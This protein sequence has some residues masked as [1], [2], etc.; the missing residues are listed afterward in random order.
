MTPKGKARLLELIIE[1][2]VNGTIQTIQEAID[3]A[4]RLAEI[5]SKEF[6]WRRT[7]KCG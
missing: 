5:I 3:N 4:K 1:N 7:I 2:N 6:V